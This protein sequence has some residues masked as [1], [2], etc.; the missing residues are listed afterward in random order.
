MSRA[1]S[2]ILVA[3]LSVVAGVATG[4][5]SIGCGPD[6]PDEVPDDAAERYADAMCET[7]ERCDCMG[8][9]FADLD[10]CRAESIATFG[11]VKQ[12]PGVTFDDACFEDVLDFI[13][14]NN[15]GAPPHVKPIPCEVFKGTVVRGE[16]CEAEWSFQGP[17]GGL[18]SGACE[19]N[20][21]CSAG[22]CVDSPGVV[23][24]VGQPC[25]LELGVKCGQGNYCASDGTCREQV[26]FGAVCDTPVACTDVNQ[27][28]SGLSISGEGVGRCA[29][30]VEGG[31]MCNPNEVESCAPGYIA[32]CTSEGSCS[33]EWPSICRAIAPPPDAYDAKMWVPF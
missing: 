22:T 10:T 8:E 30:R 26:G 13:K 1:L 21:V 4:C 28:C 3:A 15:C 16:R 23:V 19:S 2:K 11:R 6:S 33:A 12:W 5:G 20:G 24:D 25:R 9:V 27:Y 14:T 17:A 18:S 32:Y 31:D 29:D 7:Y